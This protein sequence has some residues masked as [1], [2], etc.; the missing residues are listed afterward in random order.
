MDGF[1]KLI[2]ALAVILLSF[3]CNYGIIKAAVSD[4]EVR[5]FTVIGVAESGSDQA[6][7][8]REAMEDG[9]R[10]AFALA[11]EV[12]PNK[13]LLANY[14]RDKD[15]V[16]LQ[17][18]IGIVDYRVLRYWTEEN[19]FRI[20]IKVWL[21]DSRNQPPRVGSLSRQPR[22]AWN[23]E[24]V[25]RIES[26]SKYGL[27]IVI[28]TLQSLEIVNPENGRLKRRI[29]TGFKPHQ[30]YGDRY[31]VK[32][33]EY[34]KVYSLEL[35]SIYSFTDIWD[36]SLPNLIKYHL[37]DGILLA[38]EQNGTVRAFNW[39]NGQE[40]W[41]LP[42]ITQI[43]ITSGGAGCVLFVFPTGELWAVNRAGQ[44]IWVKKFE[45]PLATLPVVE[46]DQMICF[47][48][49]GQVKVFDSETGR[50]IA[51]WKTN[52]VGGYKQVNLSVGKNE[53]YLL[54]NDLSNFGHLYVYH[55]WTGRLLWKVDWEEAVIPSLIQVSDGVI[56]GLSGTF[57]A[58]EDLFGLKVWEERSIGRITGLYYNDPDLIV[59]SGNRAY[60]YQL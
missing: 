24:T 54:Y 3:G 47:L 48:T 7:V 9:L 39:E 45:T 26:I 29:K 52:I 20:E 15:L 4:T 25:D 16:T 17:R 2:P 43:E 23:R 53:V 41:Q 1:K 31:L 50:S 35:I 46:R 44:K 14:D 8:Y 13:S 56:V 33:L 37:I 6:Q 12:D 5:D 49:D 19:Q 40:L 34:L 30:A 27:S 10:K 32:N 42:A 58:R 18:E 36:R 60:Y 21:G 22:V 57:E 11:G 28:N 51:S 38:V 59:I 55:R